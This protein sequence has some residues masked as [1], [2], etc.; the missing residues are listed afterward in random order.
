MGTL[1][2]LRNVLPRAEFIVPSEANS[3]KGTTLSG[4]ESRRCLEMFPRRSYLVVEFDPPEVSDSAEQSEL[5]DRLA[6]LLWFLAQRA[7]LAMVVHSGGKSL[8]GWFRAHDDEA[9]NLRF[10]GC[11]AM[12]GADPSAKNRYQPYRM[13]FGRRAGGADQ[14]VL[15]FN[16]HLIL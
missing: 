6:A 11:A 12:L 13:P 15:F 9:V 16:P 2:G 5:F 10:I 3:R 8:L 14:P 7:P 1:E 4:K